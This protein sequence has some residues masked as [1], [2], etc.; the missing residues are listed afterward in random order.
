MPSLT[1]RILII[2]DDPISSELIEVMLQYSDTAYDITSVQTP[3]EGLRLA[4]VQRFDLFMLDYF[5][6]GASGTEVCRTIRQTDAD[7][8]IMFFSGAAHERER[9][10]A[11]GAGANDYLVKPDDLNKITETVKRLTGGSEAAATRSVSS[12]AYGSGVSA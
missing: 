11:L 12:A 2:D 6:P 10:E 3:E 5:L 1:P 9:R 4:A 8:P 7:T